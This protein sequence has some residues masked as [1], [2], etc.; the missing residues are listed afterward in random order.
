MNAHDMDKGGNDG[1]STCKWCGQVEGMLDK[2]CPGPSF[3]EPVQTLRPPTPPAPF[4]ITG[5]GLYKRRDDST[6]ELVVDGI[7][8]MWR[9]TYTGFLYYED[10]YYGTAH[11]ESPNDIVAKVGVPLAPTPSPRFTTGPCFEYIPDRYA[12]ASNI[13]AGLLSNGNYQ[14]AF[15]HVAVTDAVELTDKLIARVKETQP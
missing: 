12:I 2:E 10:G 4:K 8:G 5:P 1:I 6:A 14:Q 7:A 3:D 13:L 11:D 9:D 15:L